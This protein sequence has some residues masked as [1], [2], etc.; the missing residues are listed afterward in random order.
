MDH[1]KASALLGAIHVVSGVWAFLSG[2]GAEG[3]FVLAMAGVY[4]RL[5]QER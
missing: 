3:V 5:S 2:H 1:R 4:L